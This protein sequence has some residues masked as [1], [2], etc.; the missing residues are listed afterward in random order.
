MP[1]PTAAAAA[2]VHACPYVHAGHCSPRV[3]RSKRFTIA[4]SLQ[5]VADAPTCPVMPLLLTVIVDPFFSCE[6]ETLL[7]LYTL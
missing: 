6:V 2:A 3:V 7:Q 4:S 5:V 1:P